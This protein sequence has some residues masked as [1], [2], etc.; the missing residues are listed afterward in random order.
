MLVVVSRLSSL[1][2]EYPIPTPATEASLT[3]GLS[4]KLLP[5]AARAREAL[6]E[7]AHG[8]SSIDI[9]ALGELVK[10]LA[11][12]LTP[13]EIAYSVFAMHKKSRDIDRL[14]LAGWLDGLLGPDQGE[15]KEYAE[16]GKAKEED[17][18]KFEAEQEEEKE[19]EKA[20]SESEEKDPEEK[21][22]DI[23]EDQMVQMAQ[24]CF[25]AIAERMIEKKIS[26]RAYFGNK[27]YKEQVDGEEAE[28]ISVD[29]FLQGLHE[30][31]NDGI[32]EVEQAC[33]IKVL[34]INEDDKDIKLADLEQILNEYGIQTVTPK[35]AAMQKPKPPVGLRFEELDKISMVLMLALTEYLIKEKAPLYD[36]L[37][38]AVY[39][40]AV[41][42]KKRKKTVDVIK[43]V[44]LFEI[45]YKM[46]IKTES[47]EHENLRNFL[48]LN[49]A[50][51]DLIYVKKL[52][53]TIE[54][55]ATNED[56]RA[57][58]HDCYKELVGDD[59]EAEG[60][61]ASS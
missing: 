33:L 39:K 34:G 10:A 61:Y 53:R 3:K 35:D 21:Y 28:L 16:E 47:N 37:G 48:A 43:S 42:T 57:R 58:A 46:G 18:A 45:M 5:H 19:K 49:S 59:A 30:L 40:Q 8:H 6:R 54:Q 50:H 38:E 25:K 32:G 51:R 52:K 26:L 17:T 23:N 7:L 2:G 13:E 22:V 27:I 41:K 44:D 24:A 9:G 36:I 1:L 14:D 56:L 55:F 60:Y 20:K 29:D 31:V 4:S 11:A 12:G 15:K